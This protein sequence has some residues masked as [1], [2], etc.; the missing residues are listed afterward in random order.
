MTKHT[1]GP[2]RY[3]CGGIIDNSPSRGHAGIEIANVFGADSSD[4]RGPDGRTEKGFEQAGANARLIAAAP[5]MLEALNRIANDLACHRGDEPA[6]DLRQFLD[7]CHGECFA[8]I[9]KIE[10]T[11]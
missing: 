9:A 6:N 7:D 1:E 3:T 5:E 8:L 4:D 11:E 2:W 10:N